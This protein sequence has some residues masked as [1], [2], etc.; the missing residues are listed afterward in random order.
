MN[1][2]ISTSEKILAVAQPLIVAGGY[3]GFSYAD[4]SDAIGIRK[5]SIHHHF[6]TKAELVST[7]VD[8]YRQQTELGL[9]SLQEQFASPADQLQA[10]VNFWQACIGDA[11]LP[12]CVCA[13]LAGEMPMLPDEVAS[14]VRAHFHHLAEWLASVLQAGAE[15]H[16]FRLDQR[17]HEEA[18]MLMASV[19]GAML[20]ARAFD[21]PG[22]FAA[23]VKP[24]FARLLVAD[25]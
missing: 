5:A 14:R 2:M 25:R 10:Y 22:V 20:S 24:Q 7:L 21:D 6:P 11:S 19:H 18:Q 12:F 9:K 3:N 4:I 8:R 23:I 15:Q 1:V 16:L 17:P 13:M